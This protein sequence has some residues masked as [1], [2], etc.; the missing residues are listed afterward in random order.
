MYWRCLT[1]E[2]RISGFPSGRRAIIENGSYLE[3]HGGVNA[4]RVYRSMRT[5]W[6]PLMNSSL[7]SEGQGHLPGICT[8]ECLHHLSTAIPTAADLLQLVRYRPEKPAPTSSCRFVGKHWNAKVVRTCLADQPAIRSSCR[9]DRS[10]PRSALL[11]VRVCLLRDPLETRAS[12][13][14][15]L[16]SVWLRN[17]KKR[18]RAGKKPRS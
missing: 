18:K 12:V 5:K 15:P 16:K 13:G 8:R 7:V 10:A 11:L 3:G 14:D 17:T 6:R 2:P 4:Y 9:V 1:R